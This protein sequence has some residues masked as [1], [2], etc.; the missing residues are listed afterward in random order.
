MINTKVSKNN[1][2]I[3]TEKCKISDIRYFF[4]ARKKKKIFKEY[5]LKNLD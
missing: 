1:N 3:Y 5:M 4:N 2:S